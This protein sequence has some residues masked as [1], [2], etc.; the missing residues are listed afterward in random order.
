MATT[1]NS[2]T[3]TPVNFRKLSEVGEWSKDVQGHARRFGLHIDLTTSVVQRTLVKSSSKRLLDKATANW[4]AR[5]A[6]RQ[7]RRAA[8][9]VDAAADCMARGWMEIHR[10]FPE[11]I[12]PATARHEFDWTR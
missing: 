8:A 11:L 6:M 9:H 12:T 7:W 1:A 5:K 3:R 10:Q 4:R 2:G